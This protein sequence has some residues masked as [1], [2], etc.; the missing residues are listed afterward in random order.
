M[1]VILWEDWLDWLILVSHGVEVR[2]P[3]EKHCRAWSHNEH[4]YQTAL[5]TKVYVLV[6]MVERVKCLYYLYFCFLLL[7][8]QW[9]SFLQLVV[10]ADRQSSFAN[11][12][13]KLGTEVEQYL[14]TVISDCSVCLHVNSL[15]VYRDER[16]RKPE[17]IDSIRNLCPA[18]TPHQTMSHQCRSS[19]GY[20]VSNE[21]KTLNDINTSRLG[22]CGSTWKQVENKCCLNAV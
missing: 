1:A 17:I 21:A 4:S 12:I 10:V 2:N 16:L 6:F 3:E 5:I 9:C 18:C 22:H 7:D 14:S 20:A 19:F 15:L 13:H 8:G 11:K